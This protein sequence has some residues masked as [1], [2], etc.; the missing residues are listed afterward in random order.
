MCLHLRTRVLLYGWPSLPA[1]ARHD[2]ACGYPARYEAPNSVNIHKVFGSQLLF[3]DL[4]Q[5]VF[6]QS[7]RWWQRGL[8]TSVTTISNT[9]Q[10]AFATATRAT[11]LTCNSRWFQTMG[12]TANSHR[13]SEHA[14]EGKCILN[15]VMDLTINSR[16]F[17]A[18]L[19][20]NIL[21]SW[22]HERTREAGIVALNSWANP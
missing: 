5:D 3:N 18:W 7:V 9:L 11:N 15:P 8:T 16:C 4:R 13:S 20:P 12:L 22:A 1:C 14:F 10:P 17:T 6:L 21:Q 2:A 19:A